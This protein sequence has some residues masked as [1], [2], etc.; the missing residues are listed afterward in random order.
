[1]MQF[2]PIAFLCDDLDVQMT[3]PDSTKPDFGLQALLERCSEKVY[4]VYNLL[5]P[6]RPETSSIA[7]CGG[8][9]EGEAGLDFYA[10]DVYVFTGEGGFFLP[11]DE[12]AALFSTAGILQAR[13]LFDGMWDGCLFRDEPTAT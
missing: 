7:V 8:I 5:R 12:V 13:S 1:M 3:V 2:N 11:A 6:S 4:H 9:S 10:F